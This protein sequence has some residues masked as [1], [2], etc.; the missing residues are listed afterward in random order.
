MKQ[1]TKGIIL[2]VVSVIVFYGIMGLLWR[3]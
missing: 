2:I 1:T 3:L